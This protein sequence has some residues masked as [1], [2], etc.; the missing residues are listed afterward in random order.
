MEKNS[1]EK[2]YIEYLNGNNESLEKLYA[3]YKN[4]LVYFV[5]NIVKDYEKA[6]DIVQD[7]FIYVIENTKKEDVS[8]KY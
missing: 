8:F 3:L 1:D 4:K 5:N 2:I 7:T 6:E